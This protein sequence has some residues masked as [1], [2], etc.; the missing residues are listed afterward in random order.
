MKYEQSSLWFG[1]DFFFLVHALLRHVHINWTTEDDDRLF[2]SADEVPSH[3]RRPFIVGETK[4]AKRGAAG[5]RLIFLPENDLK[6]FLRVCAGSR[7][8]KKRIFD[9]ICTKL[10]DNDSDGNKAKRKK[11]KAS[12]FESRRGD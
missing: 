2:S 3:K 7:G 6:I 9:I 4:L 11:N 10:N 8:K 12:A 5:R 1:D